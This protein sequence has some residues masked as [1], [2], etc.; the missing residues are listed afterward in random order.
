MKNLI[1]TFTRFFA[2]LT[3]A[4]GLLMNHQAQA[5][6]V[7]SATPLMAGQN[8]VAGTVIVSAD[9]DNLYISYY[10][11]TGWTLKQTH[12]AVA[13][14]LDDIPQTGSGNPKVGN[15]GIQES[16]SPGADSAFY[17]IP[18][19]SLGT[20]NLFIATH[21]VVEQ[22][23]GSRETGWAGTYDFDGKNWA[24]YIRIFEPGD[25]PPPNR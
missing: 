3:L 14:S 23:G 7:L 10:M 5:Q 11:N 21:A 18:R 19:S 16:F 9:A 4:T 6:V 8:Y 25:G 20:L 12:V 15:F 22:D 1:P 2:L 13:T 24:T 17:T